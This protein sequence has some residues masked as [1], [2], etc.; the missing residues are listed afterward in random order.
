MFN[1]ITITLHFFPAG[2]GNGSVMGCSNGLGTGIANLEEVLTDNDTDSCNALTPA[3]LHRQQQPHYQSTFTN[4]ASTLYNNVILNTSSNSSG[5]AHFNHTNSSLS[6]SSPI[7]Q[8]IM[9]PYTSSPAATTT[10]AESMETTIPSSQTLL[11]TV[12]STASPNNLQTT[13]LPNNSTKAANVDQHSISNLVEKQHQ[14]NNSHN[15]NGFGIN[16][17]T[18]N[19]SNTIGR[20]KPAS[21]ASNGNLCESQGTKPATTKGHHTLARLGVNNRQREELFLC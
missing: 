7:L 11:P 4:P 10:S 12:S 13:F 15:V 5:H 17:V 2:H 6:S 19:N 21:S 14:Q 3:S 18:F 20:K 16:G 1:T 9:H 8:H